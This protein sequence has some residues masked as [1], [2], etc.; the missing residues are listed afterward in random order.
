MDQLNELEKF[1]E[2]FDL[3]S[4]LDSVWKTRPNNNKSS[5]KETNRNVNKPNANNH[6]MINDEKLDEKDENLKENFD[7]KNMN[8]EEKEKNKDY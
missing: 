8:E 3:N 1:E 7:F 5:K 6:D 4:M 2:I